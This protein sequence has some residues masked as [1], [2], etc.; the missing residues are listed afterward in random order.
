MTNEVFPHAG[1]ASA[2]EMLVISIQKSSGSH[3]DTGVVLAHLSNSLQSLKQ[4]YEFVVALDEGEMGGGLGVF[5][6]ACQSVGIEFSPLVGLTCLD[7]NE[8]RYLSP[9]ETLEMLAQRI[10]D[11]ALGFE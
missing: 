7:E 11:V 5:L 8:C 6:V 9:E 3:D 4:M 1:L 2:I 10:H